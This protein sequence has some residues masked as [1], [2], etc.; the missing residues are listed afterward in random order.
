MKVVSGGLTGVDRTGLDTAM[1]A[2]IPVGGCFPKGRKAEVGSILEQILSPDRN[3][4]RDNR[5]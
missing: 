1:D 4:Y 5:L 2:G 3:G